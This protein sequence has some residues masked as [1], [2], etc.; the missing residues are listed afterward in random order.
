MNEKAIIG[1]AVIIAALVG[2]IVYY[3]GKNQSPSKDYI[4][5]RC[6]E[7]CRDAKMKGV[8][9]SN[10][11][12]LSDN[13]PDWQTDDWVCDVAH[14]PRQAIDN[15]PEN[16]CQEFRSGNAHHF[17]EVNENCEFIRAY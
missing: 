2:M 4:I 13:N 11:P 9:L 15:N 1:I 10:G 7:L 12:C 16:Q 6:I 17:V 14:W 8:D 5:E 3:H